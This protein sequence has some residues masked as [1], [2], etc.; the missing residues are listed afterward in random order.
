MAKALQLRGE[1]RRPSAPDRLVK[2]RDRTAA[3]PPATP[4]SYE[5]K[6]KFPGRS[7][8]PRYRLA[9]LGQESLDSS[10]ACSLA[11]LTNDQ[12]CGSSGASTNGGARGCLDQRGAAA[13]ARVPRPTGGA[14]GCLVGN[15]TL[16]VETSAPPVAATHGV[17]R[18]GAID[19]RP[20]SRPRNLSR[21][22]FSHSL[23]PPPGNRPDR[24]S[25][26][27]GRR[28]GLRQRTIRP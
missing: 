6:R 13:R 7:R 20:V 9:Q 12:R 1:R 4:A 5:A 24:A 28:S 3:R 15:R 14:R 8:L 2:P 23:P 21:T 10:G 22:D 19:P 27:G 17:R 11:R 26:S 18:G 16:R 25:R